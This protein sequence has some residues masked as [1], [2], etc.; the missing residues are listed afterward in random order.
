MSKF[1]TQN[2]LQIHAR[3]I[4]VHTAKHLDVTTM[5]TYSHANTPLSQSG[6]VFYLSNFLK[7]I[8]TVLLNWTLTSTVTG[9]CMSFS[10]GLGENSL[11]KKMQNFPMFLRNRSMVIGFPAF[12]WLNG[13]RVTAHKPAVTIYGKLSHHYIS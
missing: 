1:S 9:I 6:S 10:F 7:Y 13:P 3:V 2:R 12:D 8:S 5:F 4:T 11:W